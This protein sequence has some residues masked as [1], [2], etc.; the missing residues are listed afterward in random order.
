MSE[1][2]VSGSISADAEQGSILFAG[3]QPILGGIHPV[4][5][6]GLHNAAHLGNY[7]GYVFACSFEE[8]GIVVGD[9]GGEIEFVIAALEVGLD[10]VH[11]LADGGLFVDVFDEHIVI[12]H[13]GLKFVVVFEESGFLVVFYLVEGGEEGFVAPN[14]FGG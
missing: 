12:V 6:I 11:F 14:F 7:P 9:E 8:N 1:E 10:R 2:L 5:A 13:H 4:G 3:F